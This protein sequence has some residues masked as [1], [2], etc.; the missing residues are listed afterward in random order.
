MM[1]YKVGI[2]KKIAIIKVRDMVLLRFLPCTS[3]AKPAK[4]VIIGLKANIIPGAYNNLP[5][6]GNAIPL[7]LQKPCSLVKVIL[8]LL[9]IARGIPMVVDH[10]RIQLTIGY[11]SLNRIDT[12]QPK[13][14]PSQN[15]I[16]QKLSLLSRAL[17]QFIIFVLMV[18]YFIISLS[19]A[20]FR[21]WS[22]TIRL[23][24]AILIANFLIVSCLAQDLAE[25]IEQ[26]ER[27]Y[28]IPSGLLKSITSVES[29]NQPFALNISGKTILASSKEQA[30]A[31]VRLYQDSGVTNIDLGI[32]QINLY[33][34]GKHFSSIAEM[35]EP[36]QNLE[37]AAKFLKE[38]YG[39]HGSWNQAVRHYHSANP[40]YHIKYA[41]KVLLAWLGG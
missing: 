11:S 22:K 13:L 1:K 24:L 16:L 33:W 23:V 27:A 18:K 4:A 8:Q 25:L 37:Y 20:K 31:I 14:I 3:M 30:V 34:H 28:T 15:M 21:L 41:R 36:K 29:G 40:Q 6:I 12:A 39:K 9:A 5:S 38:L 19:I 2:K 35:L 10:Q 26:T 17:S 7:L 32:A